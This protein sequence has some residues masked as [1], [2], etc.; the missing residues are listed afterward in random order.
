MSMESSF[1]GGAAASRAKWND[2]VVILVSYRSSAELRMFLHRQDEREKP[3]TSGVR[4]PAVRKVTGTE[5]QLKRLRSISNMVPAETTVMIK[6]PSS[7]STTS[8]NVA[9]KKL[10]VSIRNNV[11]G[12]G[13]M[14]K[15]RN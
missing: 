5:R 1:S 12:V 7:S 8:V 3:S 9:E 15:W 6:K 2:S 13:C 14:P 11:G 10:K 4:V